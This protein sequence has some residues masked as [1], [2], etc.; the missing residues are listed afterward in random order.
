MIIAPV[1]GDF[2]VTQWF[3]ERPEVYARFKYKSGRP[4]KGHNGIDLSTPVNTPIY[5]PIDGIWEVGEDPNGY[6]LYIRITEEPHKDERRQVILAHL[7]SIEIA[8]KDK[9]KA[10]E[11]VALSGNSGFSTGPHLHWGFR[12]LDRGGSVINFDNGFFGYEDIFDK[13]WITKN[14]PSIY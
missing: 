11:L 10:G 1:R 8:G 2:K 9:V 6:G 5:S 13:G 3:G 12:R 14:E 4:M 7:S